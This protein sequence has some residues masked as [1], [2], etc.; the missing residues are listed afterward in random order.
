MR[1]S[2]TEIDLH[3]VWATYRRMPLVTLEWEQAIYASI[4]QEARKQR[5]Q[6]LALGGMPDH[7][8][9]ALTMPA[10]CCPSTLMRCIKSVSSTFVRQK[11]GQGEFFGWQDCYAV[12]SVCRTHR[13]TVISYIR[14]QKQHHAEE[15]TRTEWEEVDEETPKAPGV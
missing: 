6:V 9:L 15:A 8:H 1:R 3:F 5:C 11:L 2:K 7:I 13:E 4:L 14:N 12:Y 10:F